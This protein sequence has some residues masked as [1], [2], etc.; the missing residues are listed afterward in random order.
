MSEARR[1]AEEMP[2]APHQ[3]PPES[4]LHDIAQLVNAVDCDLLT[5]QTTDDQRAWLVRLAQDA[6][7]LAAAARALLLRDAPRCDSGFAGHL[8]GLIE[9]HADPHHDL[10]TEMRWD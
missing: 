7:R 5:L 2:L 1:Q 8:C 3:I 4:P 10:M 9:G 6:E